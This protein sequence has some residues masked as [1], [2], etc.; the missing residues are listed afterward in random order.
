MGLMEALA[1][2]KKDPDAASEDTEPESSPSGKSGYRT[3]LKEAAE[4]GDWD[5]VADAIEGMCKQAMKSAK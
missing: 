4:D 3:L 5:G 2:A 1:G